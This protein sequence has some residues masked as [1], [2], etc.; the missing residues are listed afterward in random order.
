M[1]GTWGWRAPSSWSG[2]ESVGG[3][4][5]AEVKSTTVPVAW[6]QLLTPTTQFLME[7]GHDVEAEN[8]FERDTTVT[9]RLAKF[10]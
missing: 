7:V 9:L 6:S 1:T 8:T 3:S 5:G 2:A 4:P 10:F